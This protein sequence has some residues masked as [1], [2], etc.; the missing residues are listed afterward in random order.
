M[1][2]ILER[3]FIRRFFIYTLMTSPR[4]EWG[5]PLPSLPQ[6]RQLNLGRMETFHVAFVGGARRAVGA[7]L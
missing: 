3:R 7:G 6:M 2:D 1:I 5:E 4:K